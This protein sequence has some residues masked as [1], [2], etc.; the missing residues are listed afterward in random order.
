MAQHW[1]KVSPEQARRHPL[2]GVGGWLA[3]FSV[4]LLLGLMRD[5]GALRGEAHKLNAGLFELLSLDHPAVTY[6]K[7]ML[8]FQVL[9]VAAICW[10]LFAKYAGFRKL[11]TALLLSSWP[12]SALLGTLSPFPGLGATLTAAFFTWALSCA[13]WI[14]YLHRSCRVRVTFDNY[15][16]ADE[17]PSVSL[18]GT[19]ANPQAV[20]PSASNGELM[21]SALAREPTTLM[22]ASSETTEE[23]LW[24]IAAAEVDSSARRAG[25]WAKAFAEAQANEALAKANYLKWRVA[26][27]QQE[28]AKRK[29]GAEAAR[30]ATEEQQRQAAFNE[31]A[32]EKGQCSNC[33]RTVSVVEITCPFCTASFSDDS[34]YRILL[35]QKP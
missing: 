20:V 34:L 18:Q 32:Q 10:M 27:L 3:V 11:S 19:S 7:L 16:P 2:Y 26:Q 17:L 35:L 25:L 1:Q 21:V 22:R 8:A 24:A 29:Q 12:V 31:R 14:T 5:I 15:L 4:S 33:A 6:V 9:F 13:V 30:L 28:D 23:E